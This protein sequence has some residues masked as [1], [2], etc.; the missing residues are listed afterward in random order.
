MINIC[1]HTY[2]YKQNLKTHHST[3]PSLRCLTSHGTL[4]YSH[5]MNVTFKYVTCTCSHVTVLKTYMFCACVR[6][7]YVCETY[8][9]VA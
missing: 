3:K 6:Y 2:I 4:S 8:I 1:I 7:I 9:Y 5:D